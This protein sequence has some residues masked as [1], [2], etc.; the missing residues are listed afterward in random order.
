MYCSSPGEVQT[1]GDLPIVRDSDDFQ[2]SNAG[3][4]W[5]H[6]LIDVPNFQGK[7]ESCPTPYFFQNLG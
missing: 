7:G 3:F 2:R 5:T 1:L 6:Q 4:L